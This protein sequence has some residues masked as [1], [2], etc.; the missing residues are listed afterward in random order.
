[1][2]KIPWPGA[3]CKTGS[4]PRCLGYIRYIEDDAAQVYMGIFFINHDIRILY[5]T[6]RIQSKVRGFWLVAQVVSQRFKIRGFFW[7]WLR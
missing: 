1:M 5:Q 6:T 4:P 3:Q 2:I 7:V